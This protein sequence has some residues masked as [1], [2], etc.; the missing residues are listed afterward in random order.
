MESD[1][2]RIDHILRLERE[3]DRLV[4]QLTVLRDETEAYATSRAAITEVTNGVAGLANDLSSIA[5]ELRAATNQ[6]R[7][8]GTPEILALQDRTAAELQQIKRA[9]RNTRIV[10]AIS[11]VLIVAIIALLVYQV[12]IP[13]SIT[14][15]N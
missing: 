1:D 9:G 2:S 6:L 8:V 4:A 5:T 3:A 13:P 12:V 10:Q 15:I 11:I 7:E 14:F